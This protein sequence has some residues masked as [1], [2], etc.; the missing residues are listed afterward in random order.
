FL[1]LRG[2]FAVALFDRSTRTLVLARDPGGSIP[3]Y[4][5][6]R[7]GLLTF[8]TDARTLAALSGRGLDRERLAAWAEMGI[9]PAS[10]ESVVLGVEAV[11]PG[12]AIAVFAPG[13]ARRRGFWTFTPVVPPRAIAIE[14]AEEELRTAL[15]R[16]LARDLGG[17]ACAIHGDPL[18]VAVLSRAI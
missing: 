15:A 7:D 4:L 11:R 10:G 8:S 5:A 3:L 12:W 6:Q 14:Q 16:V 2:R 9:A 18:A 17:G 13:A 1:R